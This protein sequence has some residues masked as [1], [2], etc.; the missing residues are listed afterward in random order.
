MSTLFYLKLPT[1]DVRRTP[2]CESLTRFTLDSKLLARQ[3]WCWLRITFYRRRRKRV[4]IS[5]G[6]AFPEPTL[7]PV[8]H[9]KNIARFALDVKNYFSANPGA[10][11]SDAAK[12]FK[13]TRP[14]ISQLL[15]I[16]NNIPEKLL[17]ELIETNDPSSLKQFSGKQLLKLASKAVSSSSYNLN[18]TNGRTPA[19][20]QAKTPNMMFLKNINQSPNNKNASH[21][22]I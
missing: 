17:K 21:K 14:R 19:P 11:H 9:P 2:G 6:E 16:A 15:K 3:K 18:F 13:V 10:S 1:L 12:H 22:V 5:I 8:K 4:E 7:K 20:K